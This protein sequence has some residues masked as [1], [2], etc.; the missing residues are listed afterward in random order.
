MSK[1]SFSNI[2]NGTAVAG[3]GT[4]V[5]SW[6]S[7]NSNHITVMVIIATLIITLIFH[8]IN[9]RLKYLDLQRQKQADKENSDRE[10][11]RIKLEFKIKE[12]N[13]N[14]KNNIV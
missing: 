9:S 8:I 7:D 6:L 10:N 3:G 13:I 12:Q 5:L 14:Y 2:A 11:L 4:G 1:D